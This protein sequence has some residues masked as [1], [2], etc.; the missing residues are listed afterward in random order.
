MDYL[1]VT[2]RNQVGF[3]VVSTV[4]QDA[5]MGGFH[6]VDT[7]EKVIVDFDKKVQKLYSKEI[8]SPLVIAYARA[9]LFGS[10]GILVGFED[11]YNLNVKRPYG[12]KIRYLY[13]LQEEL[14][15]SREAKTNQR[16][17]RE[18]PLELDYYKLKADTKNVNI[19][20]SRL[21]HIQPFAIV[22]DFDGTSTLEPIYDL[23]TILKNG[24]WSLG[25][26]LFRNASGLTFVIPG[27]GSSQVQID[28]IRDETVNA[29][30]KSLVTL[31]PGC[32]VTSAPA[33]TLSPGQYYDVLMGQISAGC[34]I[35]VSILTGAQ[36]GQGVSENDRRDYADF[37]CGLQKSCLTPALMKIL[38]LYQESNQLPKQD[39][40][41]KWDSR[42]IFMIEEARTKLYNARTSVE[43]VKRKEVEA[44]AALYEAR[45][46]YWNELTEREKEKFESGEED[47]LLE[48]GKHE[49]QEEEE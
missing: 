1:A 3:N 41:I 6:C 20:G 36:S 43:E 28:A 17:Q 4:A 34:N 13:A 10:S 49:K 22:D 46:K 25:Q 21:I 47:K 42:S 23:L 33:S 29:N 9:R 48:E 30:A 45:A 27:A 16:G 31:I 39:F 32:A 19:D 38:K 18:F 5:V 15:A 37:L 24:D 2:K 40:K 7:E 14:I 26:N 12:K 44:R 35:P 11:S 8:E